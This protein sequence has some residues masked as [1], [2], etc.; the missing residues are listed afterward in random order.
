MN[1]I[2]MIR[3]IYLE[4]TVQSYYETHD[5]YCTPDEVDG[6]EEVVELLR[7]D[8]IIKY[9][10]ELEYTRNNDIIEVLINIEFPKCIAYYIEEYLFIF[11]IYNVGKILEN[12]Y[13]YIHSVCGVDTSTSLIIDIQIL[14]SETAKYLIEHDTLFEIPNELQLKTPENALYHIISSEEIQQ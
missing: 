13:P 10:C 9:I 14:N 12:N 1:K 3:K 8:Y 11:T 7:R 6:V 2:G 5:G 4:L